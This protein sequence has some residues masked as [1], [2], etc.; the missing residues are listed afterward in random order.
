MISKQFVGLLALLAVLNAQAVSA[1]IVSP[2]KI[3]PPPN[4][5][6]ANTISV[7][8]SA[9]IQAA[10]DQAFI[11]ASISINANTADQ[12]IKKLSSSVSKV[13][14][15]LNSNGLT[16]DNYQSTGFN[17]YPNTSYA[18]G[19]S[20]VVGQIASQD[21]KITIPSINPDG[22]NIGKLIDLLAAVNGIIINGLSFD[23]ANKTAVY[24]QAR[25][26]AYQNAQTKAQDYAGALSLSLGQILN[27]VD[28]FSSAPV[29]RQVGRPM[30]MALKMSDATPTT[31]NVG[32]I[33]ISYD[34]DAIYGFNPA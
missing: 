12:A 25:Q 24:T 11:Q 31:V 34:L 9:T 14:N 32:T 4:C 26:Q 3:Y 18:N 29:V 17:L 2:H 10:P 19:V 16:A 22:S 13:L 15:I 30:E 33:S 27:V 7:H 20:T 21:L 28:S 23:I 6:D 1:N 5:C 8:G